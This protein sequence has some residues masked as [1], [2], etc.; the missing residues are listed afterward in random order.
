MK[1]AIVL[2]ALVLSLGAIHAAEKPAPPNA[3]EAATAKLLKAESLGGLRLG[4]AENDVIQLLGKPAEQGKLV[5]QEAD[6]TYVQTWRYPA[7][8]IALVMTTGAKKTGPKTIT[9]I[10]ARAPCDLGTKAGCKIGSAEKDVRQA[11]AQYADPEQPKKGAE[12]VVG[13]VYDGIIF[14]FERGKVSRIFFG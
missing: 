3:H 12:F 9:S 10:T 14:N 4:L 7:K 1:R 2:L 13:S 11:Y 5:L 8:G 6:A